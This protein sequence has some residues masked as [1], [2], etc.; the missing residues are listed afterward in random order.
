MNPTMPTRFSFPFIPFAAILALTLVSCDTEVDLLAPYDETPVI[1][2]VLDYTA[3][4]QFVRINKTFLGEGDPAQYSAIKDSVEYPLDDV[5]AAIIKYTDNGIMLD[6]IPLFT[7]EI[8][9]RDPGIFYDEDVLFYFT[10]E[11]L[12]SEAELNQPEEFIFE[13]KALIRGEIYTATTQFPALD[14]S[15][16][17]SPQLANPPQEIGFVLPGISGNFTSWPFRFRSDAFSASYATALRLNFDYVTTSGELVED[18]FIDY[19]TGTFQNPELKAQEQYIST[20]FGQNWFEFLGSQLDLIPDLEEVRILNLEWRVTGS[21]PELNTYLEVAQPV[22]QF[23]PVLNSYTN[24][25]NGGIGVFSSTATQS[26][27]A[28]MTDPTLLKLNESELTAPYSFCTQEWSGSQ[29][30]CN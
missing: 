18:V 13:F 20:V 26:R 11:P 8:P 19:N 30:N 28:W 16:I 3:D 17:Q 14:A 6:S 24:I 2:G 5:V 27:V 21:A 25:S 4:T 22:S 1:Y 23:T 9:S 12:L 7:T 29:Y 15:T 10:E